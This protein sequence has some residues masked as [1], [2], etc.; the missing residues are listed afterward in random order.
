VP[1]DISVVGFDDLAYAAMMNPPLS[2]MTVDCGMIGREAIT[3]L[4]R[5]LAEPHAFALQV[6]CAVRARAGATIAQITQK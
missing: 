2:T 3:L 4:L 5:R 6:E 1:G